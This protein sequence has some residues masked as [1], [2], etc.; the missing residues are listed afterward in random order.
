MNNKT[1]R[2]C[3]IAVIFFRRR[4]EKL[5]LDRLLSPPDEHDRQIGRR[6][7]DKLRLLFSTAGFA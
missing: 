7:C 6:E 1:A 3:V 2:I 4:D 5:M